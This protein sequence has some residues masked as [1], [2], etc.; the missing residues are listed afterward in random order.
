MFILKD[1]PIISLVQSCCVLKVETA[2]AGV[3]RES[4]LRWREPSWPKVVAWALWSLTLP[5]GQRGGQSRAGQAQRLP[6]QVRPPGPHALPSAPRDLLTNGAT[7]E[8][9]ESEAGNQDLC[10]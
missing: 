10:T 6:M 4:V 9:V 3:R 5:W 2:A 1:W 7:R 8:T